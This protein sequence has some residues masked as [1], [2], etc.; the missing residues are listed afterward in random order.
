MTFPARAARMFFAAALCAPAFLLSACVPA[1]FTAAVATVIAVEVNPSTPGRQLDD[2]LL[3]IKLRNAIADDE[4]LDPG[5]NVS[6]TSVNGV[7]LLSGEIPG[8][9][10][11]RRVGELA[12][13]YT[14]TRMVVN[15][16]ELAG[17]TTLTS[18]FN[19]SLITGK[20]KFRLFNLENFP[21]G[22][23]KVV[24]EHGKVYL[25]GLVS[26]GEGEAAVEAIRNVRGITR[27][28]KVFEYT[29]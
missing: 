9:E 23:V 14:E 5:S 26:R 7:V 20:V 17:T 13:S 8:D 22:K 4:S 6:V 11:R 2:N 19:D 24:T 12:K 27:I 1:V 29:D 25:L 21:S 15:E 28:V 18:R 3:E 16:L 10:Q